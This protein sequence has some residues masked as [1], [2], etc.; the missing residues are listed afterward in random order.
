MQR[1]WM[2]YLGEVNKVYREVDE[3]F[4]GGKKGI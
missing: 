3:E 4:M 1:R 2:R